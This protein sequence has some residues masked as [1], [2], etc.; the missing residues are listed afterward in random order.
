MDD[1]NNGGLFQTQKKLDDI[2][3]TIPGITKGVKQIYS[4]LNSGVHV[5]KLKRSDTGREYTD[6]FNADELM[7]MYALSLNDTQRQK[8]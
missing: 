6:R 5:L 7:R 4:K 1:L 8:L 2:A 3:N